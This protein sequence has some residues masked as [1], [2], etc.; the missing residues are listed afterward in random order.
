MTQFDPASLLVSR[1]QSA[2][3]GPIIRMSQRARELRAGGMDVVSLTLGEPDFDTPENI[4]AAATAA[5]KAGLTHYSPV[6]GIPELRNALSAKLRAENGLDYGPN[7]IC[8]SNGAK[9]AIA[10]AILSIVGDGDEVI[11]LAPFWVSY[12][13]TVRFAGGTPKVLHAG[14]EENY[15]VPASRIAAAISPRTK[16]IVLNSPSNPTGAVWTRGELMELAEVVKSHPHLMV[17]S[18]EIYEYIMFGGEMVSIGSL[19]GMRERTITVNGFSKGFAMTGWRLGYAAAPAPIAK[20]MGRMQSA[21]T[22]GA[23]QFVQR[24]AIAALEG[25]RGEVER[26]RQ[27]YQK[28]RDMVLAGLRAIPGLRIGDIPATFYAFPDVSG[29]LGRKAGN[30][31]IDTTD[32]LCDW[33][34]EQ[35]GVA[36]VPGTAFGAPGSIRLSFACSETE[37][38]KAMQRMQ[39]ALGE[40]GVDPA[41]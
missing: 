26:M 31:V 22:A 35:H 12:E 28:R 19:P 9:Q 23:N 7:D 18:D 5:M 41:C 29:L 11:M 34:L 20:A 39:K 8:V 13:I 25:P 32:A 6:M 21:L 10:N 38:A 36:T 17:L 1:S 40:L 30:H 2:D 15:K 3:E 27:E 33:L 4:Q 16:L 37:I 24:A 14:V